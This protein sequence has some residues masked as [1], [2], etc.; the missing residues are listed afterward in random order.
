MATFGG[1]FDFPDLSDGQSK[2]SSPPDSD[3][4]EYSK[5]TE[6]EEDTWYNLPSDSEDKDDNSIAPSFTLPLRPPP[7]TSTAFIIPE[8]IRKEH[9]TSARI[10]AIYML[11]QRRSAGDIKKAI[12]VS[13]TRI[14]KL[15]SLAR[16]RG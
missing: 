2:L 4:S 12:G 16:Q 6:D 8:I 9:L 14:Y 15:A 11:K 10:K 1:L 13:R 5:A 3:E 7:S